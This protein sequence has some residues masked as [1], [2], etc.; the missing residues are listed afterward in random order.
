MRVTTTRVVDV[1]GVPGRV[2]EGTSERGERGVRVVAVITRTVDLA[3][4]EADLA[5]CRPPSPASFD[6]IPNRLVL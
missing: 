2:W 3:E 5:E 6:A 4:F 1:D